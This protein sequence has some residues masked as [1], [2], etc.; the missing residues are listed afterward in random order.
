MK[1]DSKKNTRVM[2]INPP[3]QRLKGIAHIYLPIGL[4][5]L[6]SYI[7]KDGGV[8]AVIYNAELPGPSEK[9]V[10]NMRYRDMLGFHSRY[11]DALHDEGNYVWKEI[12]KTIAD[13]APDIACL[14]VMTAKYGSALN[15]SKIAKAVN[16]DCK[17][18]WGGPHPTIEPDGVLRNPAVDYAV[19]GEGEAA[20]K[21]LIGLLSDNKDPS[22]AQLEEIAGLSYKTQ[23]GIRHN[24]PGKLMEDLD[25]LPPPAKEKVLFKERYLPSSWGDI[26]TLRGCPFRCGYCGAHNIWTRR[27]RYRRPEKVIE[28]I[29]SVI[30]RYGTR[31]FYFWDDNF[32]LDR[33]RTLKLCG[34]LRSMD[35][36]ISWGCTTRVD[37]LDDEIVR[38]MKAAGCSNI[39]IGI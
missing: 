13:F 25:A 14:T 12:R 28:E 4:G 27:V 21:G 36:R 10:F 34:L 7:S 8:E 15:V 11:I 2:L 18:V 17:V 30:S 1:I 16:K 9:L 29:V 24:P 38:E 3:F 22:S 39:S 23:N 20:L 35:Q 26:I 37:I 19:R 31:E 32:T 6:T 5:Y 33:K